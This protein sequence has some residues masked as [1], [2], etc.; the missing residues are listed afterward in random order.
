MLGIT[1]HCRLAY[2]FTYEGKHYY[3]IAILDESSPGVS[4]FYDDHE[5]EITWVK[6]IRLKSYYFELS[7]VINDDANNP[8]EGKVAASAWV[9]VYSTKDR[10]RNNLVA[11][12]EPYYWAYS[13]ECN[14]SNNVSIETFY[15]I[16]H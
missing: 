11:Q 8:D 6:Q 4:M 13:D 15:R 10:T 9:S 5:I 12:F 1:P 7:I 16:N 14:P 2:S 3:G